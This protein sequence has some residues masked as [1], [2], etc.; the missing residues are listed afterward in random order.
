LANCYYFSIKEP[1]TDPSLTF[2]ALQA[3]IQR[4]VA[5]EEEKGDVVA[6]ILC[7][8]PGCRARKEELFNAGDDELAR[9]DSQLFEELK[10]QDLDHPT[11]IN[12]LQ[13]C[14]CMVED[15]QLAFAE[16]EEDS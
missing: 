11:A 4:Y 14:H 2:K 9:R 10:R 12:N 6:E 8:A 16:K 5:I 15:E 1:K 7:S 13:E 3:I